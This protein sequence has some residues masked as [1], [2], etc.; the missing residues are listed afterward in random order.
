LTLL[1]SIT[2]PLGSAGARQPRF[3]GYSRS[4]RCVAILHVEDQQAIR[5][6]V[7]RALEAF[8]V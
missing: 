3:V 8:G 7:Q 1:A 5:E 6:L 4:S 2:T